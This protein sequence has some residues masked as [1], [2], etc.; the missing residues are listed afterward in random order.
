MAEKEEGGAGR[1]RE[2]VDERK[3]DLLALPASQK[4]K[5]H[6][7]RKLRGRPGPASP[8]VTGSSGRSC[9]CRPKSIPQVVITCCSKQTQTER[10][11]ILSMCV[12]IANADKRA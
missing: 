11:Y 7:R 9:N 10:S 2:T 5:V 12:D 4:G 3:A 8:P 6:R 1:W